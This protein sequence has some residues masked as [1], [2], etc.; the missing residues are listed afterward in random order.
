MVWWYETEKDIKLREFGTKYLVISAITCES[1]NF[2]SSHY[3]VVY[4]TA[5]TTRKEIRGIGRLEKQLRIKTK[6]IDLSKNNR[7]KSVL[8]SI[9]YQRPSEAA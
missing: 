2:N 7:K 6:I 8:N 5:S 4:T 1:D 3:Y 9:C